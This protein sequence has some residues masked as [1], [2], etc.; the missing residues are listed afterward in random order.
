MPHPIVGVAGIIFDAAQ[1]IARRVLLIQ[2]AN[3][4]HKLLWSFPGGRLQHGETLQAGMLREVREETGIAALPAPPAA[5]PAAAIDVIE[6]AAHFAVV[7]LV[8]FGCGPA[9]A[10]DDAC[11]ARWL[12][13]SNLAAQVP[14]HPGMQA[15]VDA[16]VRLIDAGI[17]PWPTRADFERA[18]LEFKAQ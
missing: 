16:A 1:P 4:P 7:G 11:D 9:K 13:P 6:P 15:A 8:G 2:R 12:Q 17:I 10:N 18:G 5:P 3:A 14:A